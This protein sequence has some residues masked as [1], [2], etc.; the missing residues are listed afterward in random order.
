[1]KPISLTISGLHSFRE[2][3]VI[4]F[5]SLCEG[6][7]F[8]IFGP[9][10]SGKSSILDAMTLALYGKVER[11]ANNTQGILNHAENVLHVSFT[12]EL[13]NADSSKKYSVERMFKRTDEQRVKTSLCRI[14]EHTEE[15]V[16][17]ADKA[18]EVN[19][20]VYALLGLTIDDFTRAVVLPQGKFAE[21]LSLKGAERRQMLQRLFHLEQYGDELVKKLRKRLLHAKGKQNELTAEQAGLG[22]A[23]SEAVKLAEQE[24]EG[25]N[26]LFEKRQKEYDQTVKQYDEYEEVWQLQ[27]EKSEYENLQSRLEQQKDDMAALS[28]RLE[29]AEKADY[30]KPY[31]EALQSAEREKNS[32]SRQMKELQQVLKQHKERYAQTVSAYEQIREKKAAEEPV[33][34]TKKEQLLQLRE[35]EKV[36]KEELTV[37]KELTEKANASADD[38]SQRQEAAERA[39]QLL[40]KALEKQKALKEQMDQNTVTVQEREQIRKASEQRFHLANLEASLAEWKKTADKKEILLK[41]AEDQLKDTRQKHEAVGEK[42]KDS[43]GSVQQFYHRSCELLNDH[44]Q[45]TETRKLRLLDEKNKAEKQREHKM[46]VQLAKHLSQNDPCPVCGSAH[47]PEPAKETGALEISGSLIEELEEKTAEDAAISAHLQHL[48][49][50]WEELSREMVSAYPFLSEL[51]VSLNEDEK[52]EMDSRTEYKALNQ[53]FLQTKERFQK[54]QVSERG[55][56]EKINQHLYTQKNSEEDLKE[57]Y[58]KHDQTEAEYLAG[59]EKW[60]HEFGG[61]SFEQAEEKQRKIS[62]KDA[63]LEELKT[64]V[65]I[66]VQFIEEKEKQIKQLEHE[67]QLIK[68]TQI[69]LAASLQNKQQA[70]DEKQKRLGQETVGSDIAS[71]LRET[72]RKLEELVQ[73]EKSLYNEWQTALQDV[74]KAESRSHAAEK[75]YEQAEVRLKQAVTKWEQVKQETL[76]AD[77]EA[78]VRSIAAPA[79]KQKMKE[80]IDA[81]QDKKKQ[82]LA[83]L[84]RVEAKLNNRSVSLEKW[85]GI[86]QF[87]SESKALIDLA[88]QEKGAASKA[89]QLL[90]EKHKRFM[91]IEEKRVELDSLASRLEKLQSVFKGNGFVEF[92]AEEQLH[93]VAEDASER[94]GQLT[95]QRYAIEVDS[96]GGFI[97]RDDANGGVR[98]PVSSL[99]GGETFLT[100]LAL[101]LSLSSQIQLRGEYPLQ[102]FFLDEGFG[103]LDGELL[104]TVISALEKLQSDNLAVGVISHVQELRARLPRK[105]IVLPAEPTGNGTSV[106]LEVM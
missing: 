37:I 18:A 95:R 55:W 61:I 38:L 9:T 45:Q 25:A 76:F 54:L 42:I 13:E 14:M 103:T 81:Y 34:V 48:K 68:N 43:F 6:G 72:D 12:F 8:G 26:L 41:R 36:L 83:D 86:K 50:K 52:E 31:A 7:V 33:L 101:A 15:T 5:S 21:F 91:E 39:N 106:L 62:E 65:Q 97:M 16:V 100:S 24:L 1:M 28:K 47:H 104:E 94:L 85:T 53:D 32:S 105:L 20:K 78:A 74:Q 51:V 19:E 82:V 70:A 92:L 30:V 87:K 44:K 40:K 89:L 23:S 58:E 59:L 84:K 56:Q 69:E 22:D 64:R 46:A 93:L 66:S 27:L 75:A 98:R 102:F 73:T 60:I 96:G 35:L 2:K 4:D 63:V 57:I 90:N 80:E 3:Q 77:L 10:G 99:S 88:A 29:A 17:L 49:E 79:D 71:L 11:A 67:A